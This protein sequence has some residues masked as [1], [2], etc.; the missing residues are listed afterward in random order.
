MGKGEK[1]P[2]NSLR[3][4]DVEEKSPY[5]GGGIKTTARVFETFGKTQNMETA[6]FD[7]HRL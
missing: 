4:F 2:A 3:G 6:G 5:G 7:T 1:K